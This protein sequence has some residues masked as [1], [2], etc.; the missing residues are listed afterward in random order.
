M[1]SYRNRVY[2][3]FYCKIIIHE[4]CKIKRYMSLMKA[5]VMDGS[6]SLSVSGCQNLLS[7]HLSNE[8]E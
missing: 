8:P 2:I 6:M 5:I 4:L 7:S 1:T 3:Y